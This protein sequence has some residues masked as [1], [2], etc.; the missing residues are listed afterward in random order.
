MAND[1]INKDSI[2]DWIRKVNAII[3]LKTV[4][5]SFPLEVDE[6]VIS[7]IT[8]NVGDG[9]VRVGTDIDYIPAI[10][11][12]LDP[13]ST[14]RIGINTLTSQ[15]ASFKLGTVPQTGFV[16]IWE[17]Q[18]NDVSV[19]KALDL[20]TWAQDSDSGTDSSFFELRNDI[21]A[22]ADQAAENAQRIL[23]EAA[24]TAAEIQELTTKASTNA[25]DIIAEAQ[26]RESAI[27]TEISAR[28]SA[29][30]A[31]T[32]RIDTVVATAGDNAA[33]IVTEQTTRADGDT[34]LSQEIDSLAVTVSDNTSLIQTEQT[35]RIDDDD[36]LAQDILTLSVTV[37]DNAA[38]IVT[39]QTARADDDSAL[40]L[41]ISTIGVQADDNSAAIVTEQTAR[42]DTDSALAQDITNLSALVGDNAAAIETEQT[43]RADNDSALSEDITTITST[44][45]GNTATIS[46]QQAS[47]DGIEAQYVLTVEANGVVSGLKL[48]AG[49]E[50]SEFLIQADRFAI[51]DP[52]GIPGQDNIVPFKVSGGVVTIPELEV[53]N[54]NIDNV[55]AD[56]IITGT[57][58]ST[59]SIITE[60]TIEAIGD[61][62]TPVVR[63][64]IGNQTFNTKNYLMWSYNGTDVTF[65]VDELGNVEM[66]GTFTIASGS[67]GVSNLSDA[68][69]LATKNTAN[70]S[71]DVDGTPTNLSEI[72]NTEG[73]KLGGI[74]DNA[75]VTGDNNSAGIENQGALATLS[76]VGNNE[77]TFNYAAST[78]KGGNALDTDNVGGQSATTVR[79]GAQNGALYGGTGI[80]VVN[81]LY[82][83]FESSIQPSFSTTTGVTPSL[84]SI[85]S[86]IGSSSLNL[87]VDSTD[88]F[89]YMGATP[90]DY[91]LVID[92]NQKW[93][94]SM[95]V[96]I[97]NV[98]SPAGNMQIYLRT[99]DSNSF[100]SFT[101]TGIPIGQWVRVRG[102]IDLSGDPSNKATMR[103]DP[104]INTASGNTTMQ[105]DGIM[106]EALVG[107]NTSPSPYS[108]PSTSNWNNLTEI[109]ERFF[110]AVSANI[111]ANGGLVVTNQALG[112]YSSIDTDFRTFIANDGTFRFGNPADN[113]ISFNGAQLQ[114][115]TDN[116]TV[117]G[118]GNATFSGELIAAT[119]VFGN[120]AGNR[121]E[122]DGTNLIIN[123][124]NLTVDAAGNA[125]YSG[126]VTGATISAS[127]FTSGIDDDNFKVEITETV[128]CSK[129][130]TNIYSH[131]R[132]GGL[133]AIGETGDY[134]YYQSTGFNVWEGSGTIHGEDDATA[135]SVSAN[136]NAGNGDHGIYCVVSNNGNINGG[137]IRGI[138]YGSGTAMGC[139]STQGKGMQAAGNTYDFYAA[140]SGSNYGPF[141]GAHDALLPK[142]APDYTPGDIVKI[143]SIAARSSLSN[144]LAA[145]DLQD[146]AEAKSSF[147]VIAWSQDLN[148]ER[149]GGPVAMSTMTRSQYSTFRADYRLASVNG[150][151]EGQV[152][153]CDGK[154]DIE[155]GDFITSSAVPGKGQAYHGDDMRLV[156]ARALEPV[157]WTDEPANIKMVACIY[158][159]G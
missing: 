121:V 20:R 151:G 133:I 102:V 126:D 24:E 141:T 69:T 16:P 41:D 153:V 111:Q 13:A 154:G 12:T 48:A 155:V 114:I 117:D 28:Q 74:S 152:N 45:D 104:D 30:A 73:T 55:S 27:S 108:I 65:G 122:Y 83:D 84:T 75:D 46:T 31:L 95:Y 47:I 135:L 6:E 23:N 78:S 105:I 36:A 150:V 9:R 26:A 5:G 77:I 18:T 52:N 131:L 51:I 35:A 34:A 92:P 159:C 3:D 2:R 94:V 61:A 91:N 157:V 72:N 29:D 144:V 54:G 110:D 21:D 149:E 148:I 156:V 128:K 140:G 146:Q 14:Y 57:L 32:T 96:Y 17:V 79:D 60:G 134:G 15:T 99:N 93:L 19:S 130:S 7:P 142:T 70:Y 38:A 120:P 64:G 33:A 25:Q 71:T 1:L 44:V 115:N 158:M 138:A 67:S 98:N 113:F 62:G 66:T 8:I 10:T 101:E 145:I 147:G 80:N 129:V 106:M 22:A 116:F 40:A 139:T 85:R 42:A 39:E 63:T 59:E 109:P 143:T 76:S 68:G 81:P 4:D 118:A 127:S 112:F 49:P 124:G 136:S 86:K 37:G 89:I 132:P 50:G 88:S 90:T 53:V 82:S 125:T 103:I 58:A 11:L 100:F 107:T 119:G 87:V 123:T 137:A 56:K 43:V 97:E